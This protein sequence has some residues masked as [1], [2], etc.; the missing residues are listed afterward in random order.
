VKTIKVVVIGAGSRNFGRKTIVDLLS[1]DKLKETDLTV[2][3]VD[4]NETALDRMLRFTQIINEYHNSHAKIEATTDRHQALKSADYVIA[5]VAS[6]RYELWDRDF[7]LPFSFGFKQTLGENG[8]SGAAFH[9]LTSIRFVGLCNAGFATLE[10]VAQILGRQMAEIDL[11]IGGLN[12]FHWLLNVRD[13]ATGKDLYPMLRRMIAQSDVDLGPFTKIMY[14]TFNILPF[15]AGIHIGEYVQFAYEITG[16]YFHDPVWTRWRNKM[17]G[18]NNNEIDRI[19]QVV[20]GK[21]PI[22]EKLAK[23]SNGLPVRIICG[24]EFNLKSQDLF[25]NIPND[26]FAISNLP[27]DAIVEI[28]A[29]TDMKGVHPIKVGPLPEAIAAMCRIQI[30]IQ[31]LLVDA[32]A[33]HSKK[34]LLQALV[35]DPTVDSIPRAQKL[36]DK[37]LSTQKEFLPELQ[38]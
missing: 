2:G 16:P 10:K 20:D 18:L 4:V 30:S 14:E 34:L 12:H 21:E 7:Y 17:L 31:K 8:G 5:A 1:S 37:M 19:Q 26:D 35:I 11:D 6:K 24:I 32:Y 25:V 22:S 3:L 13:K 36:V 27:E 33:Q 15:P 28:K 9:M 38:D 29:M 23:S